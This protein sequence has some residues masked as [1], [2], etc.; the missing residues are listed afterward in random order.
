MGAAVNP[1]PIQLSSAIYATNK[2]WLTCNGW[3]RLVGDR[4][5]C[6]ISFQTSFQSKPNSYYLYGPLEPWTTYSK[7]WK[8][9]YF[10]Y[11][12]TALIQFTLVIALSIIWH[13]I[14]EC[15]QKWSQKYY[16]IPNSQKTLIF[17]PPHIKL[18]G[19]SGSCEAWSIMS[20]DIGRVWFKQSWKSHDIDG[21]LP[22]GPYLPCVSMA[23]RAFLAGYHWYV[24]TQ[25]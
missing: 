11:C 20:H 14:I 3:P 4:P 8:K 7:K 23:G 15:N 21:I 16:Y 6:H 12:H 22:K 1:G 10:W 2:Q 17:S 25:Q 19:V 5:E 13:D 24:F 18:L 9:S